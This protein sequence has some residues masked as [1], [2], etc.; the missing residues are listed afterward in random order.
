LRSV[1]WGVMFITTFPGSSPETDA[2]CSIM[3]LILPLSFY[4]IST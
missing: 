1:S 2:E 3:V 4:V